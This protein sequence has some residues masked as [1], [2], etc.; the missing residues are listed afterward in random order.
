MAD[1][2]PDSMDYYKHDQLLDVD[3]TPPKTHWM[4]FKYDPEFFKKR[5]GS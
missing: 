2:K 4:D 3:Y 1:A 5:A